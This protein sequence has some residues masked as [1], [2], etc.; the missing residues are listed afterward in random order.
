[1]MRFRKLMQDKTGGASYITV[2]VM[3]LCF[4]L[5]FA[6]ILTFSTAVMRIREQTDLAKLTLDNFVTDNS[7]GTAGRNIFNKYLV[8]G[9]AVL[10]TL[11][12][13]SYVTSLSAASG[14]VEQNGMLYKLNSQ[15]GEIYHIT[16]PVINYTEPSRK[17]LDLYAQ[18]TMYVP[19]RFSGEI[20]SYAHVNVKVKSTFRGVAPNTMET[21]TAAPAGG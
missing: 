6:V 16:V 3:L 17:T 5:V 8:R 19:L 14:L 12:S 20:F 7:T 1:M 2:A 15:G 9:R 10:D 21:T 13:S 4:F 18:F 11:D